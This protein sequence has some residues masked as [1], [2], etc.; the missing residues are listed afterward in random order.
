MS[1]FND[2][3]KDPLTI[4]WFDEVFQ[5]NETQKIMNGKIVLSYIPDQFQKVKIEGY[6]EIREGLPIAIKEYVVNY[7]SGIVTFHSSTANATNVSMSYYARGIIQYGSNRV[8][9]QDESDLLTADNVEDA[10]HET[11]SKVNSI[12]AQ[13]DNLVINGDSSVEAAQARTDKDNVTFASLKARLDYE[14]NKIAILNKEFISVF[15]YGA[16]GDGIA[17]DWNAINNA[18]QAAKT[19]KVKR[20][21]IPDGTYL[22]D[23][24][25]VIPRGIY[26]ELGQNAFIRPTSGNF[27]IIQM[28]PEARISGGT[29]D[30]RTVTFTKACIY[31][32]STEIFQYYAQTHTVSDMNLLGKEQD[33]NWTGTG[34]LMEAMTKNTYIDNVKINNVTITNF[35]KIIHLRTNTS[36]NNQS[37]WVWINANFFFQVTAMNYFYG[38]Y[39]QGNQLASEVSGNMFMQC[40]FQ[41][42]PKSKRMLYCEGGSNNVFDLITWDVHKPESKVAFEFTADTRWNE[43]RSNV[44]QE[45]FVIIDKGYMNSYKSPADYMP[46]KASK[47]H[48]LSIP[49]KPNFNGNQDDFLVNGIKRGYVVTSNVTPYDGELETLLEFGTGYGCTWNVSTATYESPI[50]IEIDLTADPIESC[51]FLSIVCP[52]GAY[53]KNA[54]FSMQDASTLEWEEVH[55][56]ANNQFQSIIVSPPWAGKDLCSRIRIEFYGS[57]LPSNQVHIAR[58]MA[59]SSGNNGNAYL[60]KGGDRLYGDMVFNSNDDGI[61]YTKSDGS[62]TKFFVTPHGAMV[63]RDNPNA[64]ILPDNPQM[65]YPMSRPYRPNFVGEQDNI[66][67]YADLRGITITQ[68][69]THPKQYGTM[70]LLFNTD[71][72]DSVRWDSTLATEANP[73]TFEV[74]T[75]TDDSMTIPY[76]FVS[77]IG[78]MSTYENYPKN[79]I[80][81]AC[82]GALENGLPIGWREILRD[83]DVRYNVIVSPPY[84]NINKLEKIR[85]KFWG[86]N[87]DRNEIAL[88]RVFAHSAK[89]EG[90]AWLPKRGGNVDGDLKVKGLLDA[91]G[92]FVFENRTSDPATPAI[93]RA[94]YRT[95]LAWDKTPLRIST[96]A[97]IKA[98]NL[99]DLASLISPAT[100]RL[101]G[102]GTTLIE[103][104]TNHIAIQSVSNGN[105]LGFT[106]TGAQAGK[107]YNANAT[108]RILNNVD[109]RIA[110]HVYNV[111]KA[112]YISLGIATSTSTKNTDQNLAA[113]FTLTVG[114]LYTQGDVIELQLAQS[115]QN[116][117]HDTFDYR[118]N[119][120]GLA[121]T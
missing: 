62:E 108:V 77:F 10:F 102:G 47:F 57:N 18:L 49:Y 17:L 35:D 54:T 100:Y 9:L 7:T 26:L 39:I 101:I 61:V 93:G 64:G 86:A 56:V 104:T 69:S 70:E 37:E 89:T 117:T 66:L 33:D 115:W 6:N 68:T 53:P 109:D 1:F 67:A 28:S 113:S 12:Q 90:K 79:V 34:I 11:L 87:N 21:K 94:W 119:K 40:Q 42:E 88:C 112:T 105:G 97:G 84:E 118:V 92:G 30:T 52:D 59:I 3:Y 83:N 55:W 72:E 19:G 81:E 20:V 60:S 85:F 2:I 43:V 76:Q 73:I 25:I 71:G 22:I 63:S 14:Q 16:K 41:S 27:H 116:S 110:M 78:L 103:D 23:K 96:I 50:R 120:V 36:I 51:Q 13:V 114:A 58:I 80:I 46:D 107:S 5:Y 45:E 91:K 74:N 121:V 8:R 95:D 48:N 32:D 111:T 82:D 29:I 4:K 99:T 98:I 106:I 31:F 75:L 65:M 44:V 15:S 38:V 24:T